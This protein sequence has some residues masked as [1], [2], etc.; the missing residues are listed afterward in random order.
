MSSG[1]GHA[2]A[3]R[4]VIAAALAAV[5]PRS[6]VRRAL[7]PGES[8]LGLGDE[9]VTLP[10]SGR[11]W[12]VGA[13][14]AALGMTEAA[15]EVLRD[16]LAGGTIAVPRSPGRAP[17]TDAI[18]GIDVWEA[19][20]PLPDAT[21]LAAAAEALRVA[22]GA[23]ENDLV[24]CL[25]SGGA[26]SLWSAPAAGVT[27]GDLRSTTRLLLHAGAAIEEMNT[28]RRHLSRIAGGGLARAAAPARTATLAISDVLGGA[29]HAIGSGPGVTDP[30]TFAEALDVLA[31]YETA[32][33]EAVRRHL[34]AGAAGALPETLKEGELP[35]EP[36]F[37]AAA[38][39]RDALAA[40][41]EEAARLGYQPSVLSD[42]LEGA[43]RDAGGA[44]GR[45][46]IEASSRRSPQIL[47]WGGETT[48]AVRGGGQ[49]GRNQE[50]ALA[51]ALELDGHPG[52]T[53]A[54][55]G[56]DGVD[57]PTPAAGAVVDGSTAS[58][59]RD[60]GLDP[61][62]ALRENDSY[63]LLA[64]LD[65]LLVTGPTGTNVNDLT[66]ALINEP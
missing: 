64:G 14:K 65:A 24:L 4:A 34:Q 56:T 3:V 33:P 17:A 40:A 58:R 57:G 19:A 11:I 47:L 9:M 46:A 7:R 62:A 10:E 28:V 43:A 36:I 63:T 55:L 29:P 42:H 44:V 45:A 35:C 20:H 49:G 2:A 51:A 66:I 60:R 48:V 8:R 21:G 39:I 38:S 54:T 41:A 1:A 59:A 50:V 32:P 15:E 18:P 37:H 6:T 61:A 31:R 30:T 53:V 22:R 12:L 52:I 26:S 27:L 5:E 16:R 25:L 13:G 23:G